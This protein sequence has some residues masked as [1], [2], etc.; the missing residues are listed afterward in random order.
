MLRVT[1][2]LLLSLSAH[3][4]EREQRYISNGNSSYAVL[5]E[6]EHPKALGPLP[7][8]K[9]YVWESQVRYG[10]PVQFA[11]WPMEA[12]MG[13]S[14][15]KVGAKLPFLLVHCE[16]DA[17]STPWSAKCRGGEDEQPPHALGDGFN[18][19]AERNGAVRLKRCFQVQPVT[20][21][22]VE[23]RAMEKTLAKQ[24]ALWAPALDKGAGRAIWITVSTRSIREQE[25]TLGR[26]PNA[27]KVKD[28]TE[29]LIN[30]VTA[31]VPDV[32]PRQDALSQLVPLGSDDQPVP[33]VAELLMAGLSF[34]GKPQYVARGLAALD[35]R[36]LSNELK[37]ALLHDRAAMAFAAGDDQTGARAVAELKTAMKG[38]LDPELRKLLESDLPHLEELASGKL[39]TFDPCGGLEVTP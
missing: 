8:V 3:A 16:L 12:A 21:T 17:R 39:V 23:L 38:T 34:P 19:P 26:T 5:A 1:F 33:A 7:P 13:K 22:D 31:L 30:S 15:V 11:A 27:P 6:P 24:E 29:V 14:K 36:G 20:P 35:L 9:G 32:S 4:A 37:A 18:D 10:Y 28:R 25:V 2:A